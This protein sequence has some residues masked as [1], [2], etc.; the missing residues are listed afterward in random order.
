MRRVL[1]GVFA[2]LTVMACE[3]PTT[4][5]AQ[6]TYWAPL[7]AT[8][9]VPPND[10][11]ALGQA[12]FRLNAAGTALTYELISQRINN[13]VQ[14]HIHIAPSGANGPIVQFLFGPV[15]GGSGPQTPD[16]VSN[17]TIDGTQFIGPLAGR[18]FSE[19]IAAIDAGNAY[20]N[21][22]TNDGVAPVTNTPGDIPAG[23][24]RGQIRAA[25]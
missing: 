25:E 14:A 24:I 23:E 16:Q 18:P 7:R 3:S 21:V 8:D 13:I 19:L 10:S 15:T 5:V 22:H 1:V 11:T 17:G 2:G 9:E 6:T 12:V 20:V 4:P